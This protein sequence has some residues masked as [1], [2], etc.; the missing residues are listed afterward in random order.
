IGQRQED[1]RSRVKAERYA[2]AR[3]YSDRG[4]GGR[5]FQRHVVGRV[6]SGDQVHYAVWITGGRVSGE[7]DGNSCGSAQC[8]GRGVLRDFVLLR[9][10]LVLRD[11]NWHRERGR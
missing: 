1:R 9:L 8:A 11:A 3:R 6:E 4:Y 5:S 2:P 10:P 7:A